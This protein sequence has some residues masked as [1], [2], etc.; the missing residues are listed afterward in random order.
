MITLSEVSAAQRQQLRALGDDG[1]FQLALCSV[2]LASLLV[3]TEATHQLPQKGRHS[4]ICEKE[5]AGNVGKQQKRIRERHRKMGGTGAL[6]KPV[7][8]LPLGTGGM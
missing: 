4:Q 7:K 2:E 6:T 3:G 8:L 5:I 1:V